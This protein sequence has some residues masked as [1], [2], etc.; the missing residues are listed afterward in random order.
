MANFSATT[1]VGNV[2]VIL[3]GSSSP[4]VGEVV[5][6]FPFG[7]DPNYNDCYTIISSELA[8]GE[9]VSHEIDGTFTTC[10]DCIQSED[11]IYVFE[12]CVN[13]GVFLNL[14]SN[15]F[16]FVP[17]VGL[18]YYIETGSVTSGCYV[19]VS[20]DSG[21]SDPYTSIYGPYEDCEICVPRNVNP[22]YF[23][24]VPDCSGNTITLNLPHPVWT[25]GYG[26]P[27]TQLN[28]VTLGGPDG[29]NN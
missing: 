3:S 20:L 8:G 11:F 5:S 18:S 13:D 25:D 2:T 28:A 23:L 9:V 22:E 21:S 26:T 6:A 15:T 12:S 14:D 24:C 19:F 17:E 27:V 10:L 29:L 16:N 1:C 4:F 7:F